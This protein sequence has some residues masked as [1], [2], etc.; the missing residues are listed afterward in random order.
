MPKYQVEVLIEVDTDI[1]GTPP[2]ADEDAAYEHVD[3]IM[4]RAHDRDRSFMTQPR[5][6]FEMLE[7]CVTNLTAQADS[8]AP[9]AT[10]KH[11]HRRIVNNPDEG[12]V[13]PDAGFDVENGDGIWRATCEDNHEDRIA[14]HEPV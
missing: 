1:E 13:D 6:H 14:A 8:I 12:W 5:W 9:S 11:C 3:N 2:L 10:C 7:G 4:Q